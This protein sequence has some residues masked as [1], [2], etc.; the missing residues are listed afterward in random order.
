ML[1]RFCI[2]LALFLVVGCQDRQ[3]VPKPVSMTKDQMFIDKQFARLDW[4]LHK[5]DSFSQMASVLEKKAEKETGR[6]KAMALIFC[7]A[8]HASHSRYELS[9]KYFIS[10]LPYIKDKKDTL[11]GK[12]IAGLGNYYKNTGD[13]PR[14]LEYFL[15]S[16]QIFQAARNKRGITVMHANIGEL[17][18]QKND[19]VLAKEHLHKAMETMRDNPKHFAYLASAHTLANVYG[20]SGEYGKA[21]ALDEKMLAVT[22]E[23]GNDRMASCFLDNKANC[24]LYS[25]RLDSA[26][27]YFNRCLEIDIRQ[28]NDKQI[29]DSYSNLGHL[30]IMRKDYRKAEDYLLKS[31][32]ILEV[33]NN[34]HNRLKVYQI[35]IKLYKESG[36]KDKAIKAQDDYVKEYAKTM[37]ASKEASIAESKIVY[38]TSEKEKII[39]RNRIQILEKEEKVQRRNSLIL[40]VS[41][42]AALFGLT[43][44]FFYRQ[45]RLKNRQQQQE[46]ELKDAIARIEHQNNLQEQRLAISRDLHDNI[47]SQLTFVISSVDNLRF[48]FDLNNSPIDEKLGQISAFTTETIGEL[49]DTIWAMNHPDISL[50]DLRGRLYN[51][52]EKARVA[53]GDIAFRFE[54]QEGLETEKFSSQ[55]GM[56]IYRC[57]QEAIH[58]AVKY[59]GAVQ[60]SVTIQKSDGLLKIVISDDGK[61][62]DPENVIK[63]NGLENMRKRIEESG[64]RMKVVSQ[65]N[66]GTRVSLEIPGR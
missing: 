18:M 35:L 45:Q 5:P 57:I 61:G 42:I 51:F 44:Y 16:L 54:M 22:K 14:T 47:G 23:S 49:R 28:E 31:L 6:Y 26:A 4:L 3:P 62:F 33:V 21:L 64:G 15:K 2:F 25:G 48:A 56:N 46:H 63:G 1:R 11:Y 34:S 7:G 39:T 10:A 12:A 32:G 50:E 36:Q 41:L 19:L 13:Y 59:S 27:Y 17:Y 40:V 30:E 8:E 43:G 9:R 60:I 52:I 20:I 65:E 55:D 53:R 38:E 58:N 29:A 66:S 24:Y 37:T